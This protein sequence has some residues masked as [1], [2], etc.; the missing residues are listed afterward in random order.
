MTVL[1]KQTTEPGPANNIAANMET[2]LFE[3]GYAIGLLG[4]PHVRIDGPTLPVREGTIVAIVTNLVALG[5][6]NW[7]EWEQ[8]EKFIQHD[9]GMIAGL[10]VRGEQPQPQ[11][12][13]QQPNVPVQTQS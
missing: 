11:T 9:C 4:K 13:P 12:Q 1:G 10:V 8:L 3:T 7:L 6:E 5:R 2:D